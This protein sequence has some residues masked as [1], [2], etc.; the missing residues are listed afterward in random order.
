MNMDERTDILVVDD[1]PENLLALEAI[2]DSPNWKLVKAGSGVEALKCL[3]DQDFALILLDVQMPG[4]DG[5][6]TAAMIRNR[7]KSRE[8]PI[9]FIT[10]IDKNETQVARGYSLGAVD[11]LFKP[12]VADTLR[13]KVGVFVELFKKSQ[14]QQAVLRHEQARQKENE[15]RERVELQR[16]QQHYL[17]MS[18]E[19]VVQEGPDAPDGDAAL[20]ARWAEEYKR[21]VGLYVRAVRIREDRP[22]AAVFDLASRMARSRISAR[23]VVRIHLASITAYA[24]DATIEAK[25]VFANDARLVLV[26]MLGD[27]MDLYRVGNVP[28]GD[29]SKN[30]GEA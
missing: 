3:L 14:R 29:A 19:K 16:Q 2:L 22:S 6:E 26:E 8:T 13:A 7:E 15:E 12:I 5:F 27:L 9:L 25:R 28:D 18:G 21:V 23:E 20:L 30:G 24:Q 17:A 1:R 4:M 10:A 11:Y